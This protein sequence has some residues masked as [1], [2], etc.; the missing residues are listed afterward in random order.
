MI[1]QKD[2]IDSKTLS[3]NLDKIIQEEAN[4]LKQNL[5]NKQSSNHK[6]IEYV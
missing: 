1:N 4:I 6:T 3:H 2:Y 5:K